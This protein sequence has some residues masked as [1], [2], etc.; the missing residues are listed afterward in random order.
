MEQQAVF[1]DVNSPKC[2]AKPVVVGVADLWILQINIYSYLL[3]V[4]VKN[5]VCHNIEHHDARVLYNVW[6]LI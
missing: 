5:N 3:N 6:K 4:H 1:C 2:N